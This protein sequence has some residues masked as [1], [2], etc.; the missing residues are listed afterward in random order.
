VTTV[1]C[2]PP[3]HGPYRGGPPPGALEV[4][5]PALTTFGPRE[6]IRLAEIALVLSVTVTVGALGR[7]TR[8]RGRSLG[9]CA[10]E[11]L[12]RG[13][14]RLGPTFVKLGQVVASSPGVFPR[15]LADACLSCLDEVPHFDTAAV[16]RV[17]E[18]DLGHPANALFTS[19]DDIPLSAASIAQV[20][21]C[22]LPD[23]RAA[24]LKVQRPGIARRMNTDL[25]ILYRIA[26]VSAHLEV[27][28]RLNVT[29]VIADLHQVTNEEL[30]FALEAHR[31][32]RFRD[33]ITAF[34]DNDM[35]TA[36]EVYW[37]FCGPR[38]ICMERLFGVP[39]DRF[40]DLRQRGI[41]GELVLRR[42]AK[43]WLEAVLVHGPFHG[44]MHAGNVWVLHD[45][46]AAFLDFGIM[47]ELE[48]EWQA[49]AA[50]LLRTFMLDANYA[51]IITGARAIGL[52]PDGVPGS[53]EELGAQL[54]FVLEPLASQAA[55][56][57]D[58]GELVQGALT[59]LGQFGTV[60][61][62]QLVLVAKQFL[63]LE[64]YVKALAPDY[65]MVQ[66]VLMLKNV[67]PA[68][69]AARAEKLGIELVA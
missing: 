66:D 6:L 40:D 31:Q 24:V 13:F 19:F 53:D 60:A 39:M 18:A 5:P 43:A 63:Y 62:R 25:R 57:V 12:V 64:R 7:L 3:L 36:P 30:N 55:G 69:A 1:D 35:M 54:Q 14:E 26:R 42:G 20:H 16:H 67:F 50:D 48:A 32:M 61:P 68:E 2:P 56:Q 23:G 4:D 8:S 41:D 51:R 9:T 58:L 46:R 15:W 33:N 11:G 52:I 29:D 10:A 59:L 27:G 28:R 37:D 21:A 65:V 47:G 17:I 45:G 34:G 38:V 44:D 49:L 22:T